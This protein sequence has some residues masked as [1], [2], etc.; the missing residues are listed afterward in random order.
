MS[1]RTFYTSAIARGNNIL[2]R[3]IRDGKRVIETV[4]GFKP[5]MF[6]SSLTNPTTKDI[7]GIPLAEFKPGNIAECRAFVDTYQHVAGTTICGNTIWHH[8]YI[9]DIHPE[10]DIAW[11]ISDILIYGIDIEVECDDGFPEP[12]KAE[13]IVNAI[14]VK[15][16][17][18]NIKYVYGL[19]KYE[20]TDETIIYKEF[21]NEADLLSSFVDLMYTSP[22]DIITGWNVQLF[23]IPY[24]V[25]RITK[26]LGAPA[27][28]RLS[29]WGRLVSKVKVIYDQDNN[30]Y[31]LAGVATLDYL[32]LYRKFV[33]EP[34]A[35]YKL[36]AIAELELGK[37]KIDYSEYGNLY[38]LYQKNFQKFIE[39]NIVDVELLSELEDKL[40]LIEL[41]LNL[42]YSAKI[43][44]DEL[45]SQTKTW[46][47][48]I[49]NYL[50]YNK[51]I[52]IP[53]KVHTTKSNTYAGAYVKDPIPGMYDWV[54][55]FDLASLYPHLMMQYNISPETVVNNL[56]ELRRDAV[57]EQKRR[58]N[59]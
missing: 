34:R 41:A 9:S 7:H 3:G 4:E 33:L 58:A 45:F 46:D 56:A 47:A 10:T 44:F 17:Q 38:T 43:N 27:A 18:T 19:G 50:R 57:N 48:I 11:D 16:S 23:D 25:N 21:S 2:Y 6:M 59:V 29:P 52:A 22:P 36:D 49:Y 31:D 51:N 26:I 35:S 20:T 37:K 13:R 28:K 39:Y 40:H 1:N 15:D 24:L 42:A 32:L 30:Y 55:S 12:E 8:Q 5:T 53:M 54:V 14:T